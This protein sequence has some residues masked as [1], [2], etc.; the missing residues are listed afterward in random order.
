VK[1]LGL[2]LGSRGYAQVSVNLTD[3]EITPLCSVFEAVRGAAEGFGVRLSGTEL[4]GLIPRKAL[5]QAAGCGLRFENF[6]PDLVLEYQ[7]KHKL[8]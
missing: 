1:A 3:F 4:V 5:E 7:L 6:H 2:Y 8:G